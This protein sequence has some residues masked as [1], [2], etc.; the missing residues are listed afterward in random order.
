MASPADLP[1]IED[2]RG[3]DI[4]QIRRQLALSVPERV[5]VMVEAANAMIAI[6]ERAQAQLTREA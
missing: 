1:V 3:V 4:S 5:R 2:E 6:Q